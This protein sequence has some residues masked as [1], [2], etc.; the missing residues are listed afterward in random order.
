MFGFD[1]IFQSIPKSRRESKQQIVVFTL[2][3]F[4]RDFWGQN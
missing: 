2:I 4:H 3:D 1:S